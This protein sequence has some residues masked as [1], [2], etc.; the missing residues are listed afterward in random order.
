MT[1]E[2][3][4]ST[5]NPY[6]RS[7]IYN[8]YGYGLRQLKQYSNAIEAFQEA[9]SIFRTLVNNNPAKY[10]IYLAR[11][12]M[13]MAAALRNLEKYDDAIVAYKEALEI[14]ITM[15]AHDPLQYNKP[16]ARTL[17][18][19]GITLG[20]LNQD[21]EAAAVEK[22]AI[23]HCRNLA[24]NEGTMLLCDALHNYGTRC[25][26]LGHYA[27]AVLV[28]QESIH[29]RRALATRDS[30][31]E[32][33]ITTLHDIS[34][35]FL[36]LGRHSE[37]NTAANGAMERHYGRALEACPRAPNFQSCFVCK[38]AVIPNSLGDGSPPVP[39]LGANSSLGSDEHSGAD[40][41]LAPAET[42]TSATSAHILPTNSACQ[43]G[44]GQPGVVSKAPVRVHPNTTVP[45]L[46]YSPSDQSHLQKLM[47]P[48]APTL[49][50]TGGTAKILVH[51]KRDRILELFRRNRDQ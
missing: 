27:E 49:K 21:P 39:V 41:P 22:Q 20:K 45:S 13:N 36:V 17:R 38:R 48:D 25:F 24:R 44:L 10:N 14:G 12:L 3:P 37:A 47:D 7:A 34:H 30:E 32:K 43:I 6:L 19:Y 40:A 15:S 1:N 29:L 5:V 9:I 46:S 35:S 42:C 8:N 18:K 2:L 28:Y 16:M 50:P 51:R 4:P 33:L 23:S 26:S 11:A 31:E